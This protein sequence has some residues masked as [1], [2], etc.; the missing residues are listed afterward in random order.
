MTKTT[1]QTIKNLN[2]CINFS[3]SIQQQQKTVPIPRVNVLSMSINA[4]RRK[5]LLFPGRVAWHKLF[6]QIQK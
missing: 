2:K 1:H 6:V 4:H 3:N 5:K